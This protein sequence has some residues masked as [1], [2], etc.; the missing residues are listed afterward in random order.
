MILK[1]PYGLLIKH[2]KLIHIII[3]A[4]ML[5][6]S[7]S[8][9]RVLKFFSDFIKN[10]YSVTV[11]DNM[12]SHYISGFIYIVIILIITIIIAVYIL[13]KD[14]KKPNKIYLLTII[15]YAVLIVALYISATLI[16]GLS[17]ALWKTAS[18]RIYRD[19]SQIIYYPQFIF[20]IIM[21][22]RGL[23]FN[24]KQ[25]NFKSDLKDLEITAEDSEEIE[26]NLN[27]QTY[28]F[29]RLIRRF[30]REFYYYYLENKLIFNIIFGVVVII[31]IF[32]G[33]KSY[34]KIKYTYNEG[35]SFTYNGFNINVEDSIITN[36]DLAGNEIVKDKYYLVLRINITNTTLN[37]KKLDYNSLKIYIGS[38]YIYPSLDIGKYFYDYGDPYMGMS[39]GIKE[40][41]TVIIP[42]ILEESQVKSTYNL[43]IYAG[44]ATKSKDFLAKTIVVKIKPQKMF[45]VET[46]RTAKIGEKVS[47][48]STLLNNTSLT[49]NSIEYNTSYTYTYENC[50]HDSCRTYTDM[51]LTESN[52]MKKQLLLIMDYE[53]EIDKEVPAYQNIKSVNNF[54]NTFMS[55]E[56]TISGK[57]YRGKVKDLTPSKVN[58]KLI[59]QTDSSIE[60]AESVN[61]IITI[62]NRRYKINLK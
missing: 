50:F 10:G 7:I 58:D 11:L 36:V 38:D 8:S 23:G 5:Y 41:K 3:T 54:A 2:F 19:I 45:D 40:N 46:V 43:R 13:L 61:L 22:I 48:S 47:F 9:Y 26:L 37:D 20:I 1:K 52:N 53:F 57:T 34:E 16:N 33:I 32:L 30:I 28:K 39:I 44:E 56:Y 17:D 49:I 25:F 27:F 15:Y 51:V 35:K 21:A 29:T 6:V 18:A 62:R 60:E 42:Y 12:A 24:I 4:L 14:K 31:T 55:L 59:L